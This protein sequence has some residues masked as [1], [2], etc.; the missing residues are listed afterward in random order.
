MNFETA[1]FEEKEEAEEPAVSDQEFLEEFAAKKDESVLMKEAMMDRM[2]RRE[3]PDL[4]KKNIEASKRKAWDLRLALMDL[5][6]EFKNAHNVKLAIKI[7]EGHPDVSIT[8][9]EIAHETFEAL[10]DFLSQCSEVKIDGNFYNP[11][12]PTVPFAGVFGPSGEWSGTPEAL[13]TLIE[14][15]LTSAVTIK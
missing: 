4:W 7:Q 12:M 8:G 14:E 10:Q 6:G 15:G 5:E 13:F 3:Y 9:G 2:E 1:A 11:T